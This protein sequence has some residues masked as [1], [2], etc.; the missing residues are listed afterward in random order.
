MIR[1]LGCRASSCEALLIRHT[2]YRDFLLNH[3]LDVVLRHWDVSI[4]ELGSQS[5][6]KLALIDLDNVATAALQKVV[7]GVH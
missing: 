4:R 5:L 3:V 2:E 6:R 1:R 7:S